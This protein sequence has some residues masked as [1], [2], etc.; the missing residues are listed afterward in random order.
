MHKILSLGSG[1]QFEQPKTEYDSALHLA[2]SHQAPLNVEHLLKYMAK[3]G[4]RAEANFRDILFKLVDYNNF[5]QYLDNMLYQ[6]DYM[7]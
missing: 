2:H 5:V 7:T 6:N 4:S 1:N 3:T